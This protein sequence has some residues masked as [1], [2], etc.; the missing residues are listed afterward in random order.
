MCYGTASRVFHGT[1]RKTVQKIDNS[2]I[3]ILPILSQEVPVMSRLQRSTL[4]PRKRILGTMNQ[5]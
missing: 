1:V 3:I 4:R 5:L 2:C